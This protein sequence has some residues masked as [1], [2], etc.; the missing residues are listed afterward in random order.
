MFY[1]FDSYLEAITSSEEN[2]ELIPEF[3]HNYEIFL[4]LNYLSLGYIAIEKLVINDLDTGDENG[5]AEFIINMRQKLEKMNI[6]PWVDN[7]FG[8]NQD[9]KNI[10]NNNEIYNAFPSSAYEKNYEITKIA[11]KK[12][13]KTQTQIINEIKDEL[14]VLSFGMIPKQ[15]FKNSLKPKKISYDLSIRS[16]SYPKSNIKKTVESNRLKDIKTFLNS[17]LTENCKLFELNSN[18]GQN[19]IAKSEKMIYIL[20]LENA[21]NKSRMV[22]RELRE[23]KQLQLLPLSKMICELYQD[24]FLS[25]RYIDKIIQINFSDKCKFLIYY[26]NIITSVEYLSHTEKEISKNTIFHSN[27]VIFGDEIGFL[28]LMIIEYK[29]INKKQMELDKIKITKTIKVHNSLIKGILYNKRLS[30]IISYS[31][32]GLIA[33][34][35]AF[36]FTTINIIELSDE[37]DIREIKVSEYDLIYIYCI[38][39]KDEKLNYIKCYSLNGIKFTEMIIE[40][41]IVN[42]FVKDNLLVVYENN[43][44]VAFNLYEIEGNPIHQFEPKENKNKININENEISEE[45]VIHKNKKIIFCTMNNIENKLYIIYD[46][47]Q[48]LIDDVSSMMLKE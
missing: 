29:I 19:L 1:N 7:V 11:L 16:E 13:G 9:I 34:N 12:Q 37:F 4:N 41:N 46:D 14:D 8:C 24:V 43:F 38:N 42:F 15:L 45:S 33:I 2:R 27:N 18:Y 47:H 31:E 25:C 44:I 23:K 35:N 17:S 22:K 30:I 36:D 6:L 3:F 40:K 20:R 26:N 10:S 28:N 48:V 5:I 39:K 21:E 32:E